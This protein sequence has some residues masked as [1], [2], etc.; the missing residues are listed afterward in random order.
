M[1][2]AP[3]L[4]ICFDGS[5]GATE[6][7]TQAARLFPAAHATIAYVWQPPVPYGGSSWGGQLLVPPEFEREI[8]ARLANKAEELATEGAARARAAG[9][10]ADTD[11]RKTK[12]PVW[13]ELL[14]AADKAGADI[15]VAGSRGY[16]EVKAMLLGSTSQALAHH[17]RRPLLVVP[18]ASDA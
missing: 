9:L 2:P 7:L 6:A 18:A 10:E 12:G 16:G 5:D 3:R 17:S 1:A 14:A 11:V 8:E 4:L 13:R 15:V